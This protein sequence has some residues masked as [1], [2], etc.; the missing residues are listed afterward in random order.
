MLLPTFRLRAGL[1]VGDGVLGD[2]TNGVDEVVAGE[3]LLG[4][5]EIALLTCTI[6]NMQML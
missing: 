4:P 6:P 2:G 1:E 3:Q 5:A